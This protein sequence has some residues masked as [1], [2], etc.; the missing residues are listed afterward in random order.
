MDR[1]IAGN[2][3]TYNSGDLH[4]EVVSVN[5][6]S[7]VPLLEVPDLPVAQAPPATT[8]QDGRPAL[9]SQT[10]A[11][12]KLIGDAEFFHTPEGKPYATIVRDGHI[13]IAT[14]NDVLQLGKGE[15][16]FA[17]GNGETGRPNSIPKFIDFDK[18]PL[19]TSKNPLLVNVLADAGIK[20]QNQ[21]RRRDKQRDRRCN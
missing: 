19:P 6:S 2:S 3:S 12:I 5:E 16:G 8:R 20:Q 1:A 10:A 18:L 21:C 15:A 9:R 13:E 11:L 4:E 7:V 14:A 17:G